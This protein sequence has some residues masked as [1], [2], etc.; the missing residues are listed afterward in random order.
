MIIGVDI[1]GT[2]TKL[3]LFS[4][5][6][7]LMEKWSID[8]QIEVE[9]EKI[10]PNTA[11]S[12]LDKLKEKKINQDEILAIG[13]GVPCPITKDGVIEKS[14]NLRWKTRRNVC[15]QL[16]ELT[17]IMTFGG[18]DANLAALGEAFKGAAK[19]RDNVV[20]VTLGTGV[21]GGIICNGNLLYGAHGMA[22][23]IGH[24]HTV[25]RD[26]LVCNCGSYGCLEQISSATGIVRLA[27]EV[28]SKNAA[29]SRLKEEEITAKLVFDSYKEGDELA[30]IV[31][32]KFA[33][34]LARELVNIS[35]VVDP[36]IFVI[37]GG[38]SAAGEELLKPVISYY[39]EFMSFSLCDNNE[40]VLASLGN[41]AGIYGAA[42]L[43]MTGL[44][45]RV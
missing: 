20:M 14:V 4:P 18:N 23:E 5:E 28:I 29:S 33:K 12:I 15:K 22:G 37:G 40:F 43:A 11:K 41:D 32:D 39:K 17:G 24:L 38:V 42:K 21:G 16:E 9:G 13:M 45:K 31:V 19:N 34:Y 36:E 27:K 1:G 35:M 30:G 25:D 2:A 26:D 3:G 6:G 44:K 10:I 7:E 8:T